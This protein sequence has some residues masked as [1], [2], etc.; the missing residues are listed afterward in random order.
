MAKYLIGIDGG[1]TSTRA[2]LVRADGAVIGFGEAGPS[3][4][5]QGIAQ[6]WGHVQQAVAAAARA[7]GLPE[8]PSPHECAIGLGLAGAHVKAR[9][10]EFLRQAP[11]YARIALDHDG[12]TALL[13]AHGGRPGV[14]VIAGTGSVGEALHADGRRESVS[15]WGF[16]VGDEG[17]GAWLGLSAMREAQRALDGR[18]KAG[19]LAQAV[20]GLAGGTR[21][22]LFAW[23]EHAGQH[24][25]AKLAP[26]VFDAEPADSAA[27]ELLQQ[28][29]LELE[30]VA[31]ALDRDGRLPLAV[32][33]S[34]GR[35][36]QSRFSPA[37]RERC[38]E[39]AG[40]AVDGALHLIRR[41]LAS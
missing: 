24:A 14:I 3:G 22:A 31:L 11:A 19:A 33:G 15:G 32:L 28:A 1:G 20:W 37:V 26:L 30:A 27:A 40:D 17:S 9:C 5:G 10:D 25:Y 38:V 41:A 21:E 12:C 34:V 23:C 35:R 4:L 29:A 13:G 7:A 36:L 39:P 8:P 16:P 18:G 2:R 6:A